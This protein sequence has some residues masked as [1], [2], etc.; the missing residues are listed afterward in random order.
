M[1]TFKINIFYPNSRQLM[2]LTVTDTYP[3]STIVNV[4]G[5]QY[6]LI[7]K[8]SILLPSFTFN[9]YNITA[10]DCLVA[11]PKINGNQINYYKKNTLINPNFLSQF[12]GNNAVD[13]ERETIKLLDNRQLS[14]DLKP[15]TYR[16]TIKKFNEIMDKKVSVPLQIT[17]TVY[18]KPDKPCSDPLPPFW[19]PQ[20]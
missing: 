12:S 17:E 1:T 4:V 18:V 10:G 2:N 16:K 19:L 3:I 14:A 7:Y 20:K 13:N 5:A 15:K 6:H 11:V 9:F 8:G